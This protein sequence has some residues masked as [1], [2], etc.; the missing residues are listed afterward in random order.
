MRRVC[1][2]LILGG[3]FL[4]IATLAHA[5]ATL[6]GVARDTSGA[7]LPGVTVEASSPVLIQKVRTA[8]TDGSGQYR[9]TDLQPGTYTVVYTLPGF[10]GVRREA[11]EVSGSGVIA[12]NVDM[13]VGAVQETV[14]VTGETPIVDTQSVRRQAVLGS[15]II[16]ALPATRSYGALL[17]AVP[18]LM[19]DNTV[20]QGAMT[21]PFMTFFTANGGRA[22]EG[23]MMI[24]GLNVAA[25]FNGG[26]VS[27]FIYDTANVEEMQVLVSGALGEAENGGPQ[28]N[29]IPKS[30]GNVFK[31]TGFYSGAGKW[32]TGS[33]LTDELKSFGLTQPAGVISAWDTS[34][35]GG[36]PIKRDRLWFF[37]NARKYSQ[38][39]PIPGAFANANAGDPTKWLYAKDPNVETRGADSRAIFSARLTSQLTPRN[40]VTFS[41]EYQHRCSGSSITLE[42]EGCRKRESN[43]I[44]VGSLTSSPESF[45]GYHDFPYNVTQ[46]TWTSPLTSRLLLESGFSRF[47]YLWAGFGIAPKD[48][49]SSLIPVTEQ[50]TMYGQANFSYRGLYDPLAFAYADNDASPTNWRASAAYVTGA[51]NLKVGYQGSYQK[52]LQARVSNQSQLW[53]R[54]NGGRPNAVGYYIAPRW[55]QNDRT[56][57]HSFYVQDQ[58]TRGKLSLQGGLR[59]DHAASWAPAE[60]NG[61]TL[62]SRFSPQPITFGRTVSVAGYKDLT[63]R[64]GAAY[65]LFGN[66]KTALKVNLGKYLQSATNDENYWANN[67]ANRIVTR[68][69]ARGWV[70]GNQNYIVDCDLTS[71]LAQNN[72]AFGGDD[73][74]ALTNNDV[75]FGKAN[76]NSTIVNPDILK[77]WGVRPYDWQFGAS[78]QQEVLPRVSV[79]VGYARRWFGNFFVTDNTVTTAADYDKFTVVVPQDSRLPTAGQTATYYNVGAAGLRA[80]QNYQ[81]FETDYADARTQYWHGI[82]TNVTARLRFGL[83][84]QGGTSTGRGVQNTCDLFKALPELLGPTASGGLAA[85]GTVNQRLESCDIVEPFLTTFRALA[86]YTVP[87]I[88]VLVSTN[89]RSVPGASLGAGSASASNG[90]SL[91]GNYNVPNTVVQQTLGRLPTGGL[92]NGNMSVNLLTPGLLYGERITQFDMRFAKVLRFGGTRA[93]IGIDLYNVFNSNTPTTYL[94]TFD[95]ATNG[96]TYLRPTAIVSPRFARFNVTVNF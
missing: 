11:V 90:T 10:V 1:G 56:E 80:A 42:G 2:I 74:G 94:Q 67:P 17:T 73:C 55:E 20:N 60:H 14:T 52:S 44:G 84:L 92:A 33:N 41:H 69:T 8:T 57:T 16:A 45:P 31:G 13:R 72:A 30:G 65:D 50:S 85:N 25:S 37:I 82:N 5:Q 75:N 23:R 68:V 59:F 18:G 38:L 76:P 39:N 88:D 15:D 35:A 4:L 51:H 93:D 7:V 91:N 27:T 77:G 9:I 63:P 83:T 66:G 24:D 54:F 95:Y 89:M 29:L 96:A 32:S 49:L 28:V 43:W 81:T 6:T 47:Q 79:E 36:G 70:D 26:G 78:V 22:N 87:K 71:T 21:R 58:W 62:I 53:Y 3:A 40:R 19:V 86:A 12:V 34:V 48:T 61:T 46:A 64:L